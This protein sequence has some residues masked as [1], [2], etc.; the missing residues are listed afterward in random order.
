MGDLSPLTTMDRHWC[1]YEG[2]VTLKYCIKA[3]KGMNIKLIPL[4]IWNVHKVTIINYKPCTN[5]INC[6]I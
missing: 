1:H 4:E 6:K 3:G 2:N 5:N